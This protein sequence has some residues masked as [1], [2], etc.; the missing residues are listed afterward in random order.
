VLKTEQLQERVVRGQEVDADTLIRL[1]GEA[2]HILTSLR[3][4]NH[5]RETAAPSGIEELV[6]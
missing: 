1:S 6:S 5:R 2:R 3:K 4:Y